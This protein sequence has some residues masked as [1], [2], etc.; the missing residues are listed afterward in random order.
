M[1]SS[2][3]EVETNRFSLEL[4]SPRVVAPRDGEGYPANLVGGIKEQA[5][6]GDASRDLVGGKAMF[7]CGGH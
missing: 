2:T 7:E 6:T 5:M 3:G 4:E 1:T